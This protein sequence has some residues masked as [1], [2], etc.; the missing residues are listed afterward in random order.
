MPKIVI[1]LDGGL[2]QFAFQFLDNDSNSLIVIDTDT[3]DAGDDE[4]LTK[5]KD[6]NGKE[7][8]AYIHE[9]PLDP[10][11]KGCDIQ[12]LLKQYLKDNV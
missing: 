7:I 11:E 2:V 6:A 3:E 9:V 12:R 1:H 8:S 5:V 4:K 10:L